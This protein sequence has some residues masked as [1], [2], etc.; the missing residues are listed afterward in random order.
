MHRVV[1]DDHGHA[2][3]QQR[4]ERADAPRRVPERSH[5]EARALHLTLV[6]R[7]PPGQHLHARVVGEECL[8]PLA[9]AS[10]VRTRARRL[11]VARHPRARQLHQRQARL[12]ARVSVHHHRPLRAVRLLLPAGGSAEHRERLSPRVQRGGQRCLAARGHRRQ[13]VFG[14]RHGRSG[15]GRVLARVPVHAGGSR[16]VI[17]SRRGRGRGSGRGGGGGM[18]LL[19]R[20]HRGRHGGE[21]AVGARHAVPVGGGRDDDVAQRVE[22][23][24]QLS[25]RLQQNGA[26]QHLLH[27][28]EQRVVL[29]AGDGHV[30][31]RAV[32]VGDGQHVVLSAEAVPVGPTLP[33]VVH[34]LEQHVPGRVA[35][36]GLH[37]VAGHERCAVD[38]NVEQVRL[39]RVL[40]ADGRVAL[41]EAMQQDLRRL[42]PVEA[43]APGALRVVQ[44]RV[45][46]ILVELRGQRVHEDFERPVDLGPNARRVQRGD[47]GD[48]CW[49]HCHWQV[50][51]RGQNTRPWQS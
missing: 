42:V 4:L 32:V 39:L 50:H 3:H 45:H 21:P 19:L 35:G 38:R 6:V 14:Q 51:I 43:H 29:R 20:R 49:V 37:R 40:R 16:S 25:V 15:C 22:A 41:E 34:C 36:H 7:R 48:T 33:H 30:Q 28:P 27:L 1:S 11:L 17:V 10:T 46:C 23:G 18:L 13:R 5:A 8:H 24:A 2:A 9:H 12:L 44:Q 31:A 47:V 26:R